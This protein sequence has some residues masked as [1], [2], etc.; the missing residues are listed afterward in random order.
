MSARSRYTR[1]GTVA[2]TQQR[3]TEAPAYQ[4]LEF[5]LNA[6]AQNALEALV[7]DRNLKQL[8]TDISAAQ[9]TLIDDAEE[10]NERVMAKRKR[11]RKL[12][13][14]QEERANDQENDPPE[15]LNVDFDQSLLD[16]EKRVDSRTKQIG[17]YLKKL[18]EA[19]QHL[20]NL[21]NA[22]DTAAEE[23]RASGNIP[24][25]QLRSQRT[26]PRG[27]RRNEE[28]EDDEQQQEEIP[29][30][31]PT[32]PSGGTQAPVVP[33]ERVEALVAEAKERYGLQSQL[34]RYGKNGEY[35]DFMNTFE[36]TKKWYKV[37]YIVR[38]GQ[39]VHNVKE[40]EVGREEWNVRKRLYTAF[41]H[42][43]QFIDEM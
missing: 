24:N 32:D 39:G 2:G 9:T 43:S 13:S 17:A 5:P 11:T 3:R 15:Y 40:T 26:V 36:P 29:E 42:V 1:E 38:H 35:A 16:F 34:Q 14:L 31:Q 6:K 7:R 27:S 18:I 30:F 20:Q 23:A 12:K 19:H 28:D 41:A 25:T 33:S 4:Q 8:E 37:F 22:I 21:K 10:I